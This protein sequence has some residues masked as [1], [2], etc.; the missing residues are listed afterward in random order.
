MPARGS[1]QTL[2][3]KSKPKY[4]VISLIGLDMR[5]ARYNASASA[6]IAAIKVMLISC[7][8]MMITVDFTGYSGEITYRI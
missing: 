5:F 4:R 2:E 1:K 8:R 3:K 6:R 7:A